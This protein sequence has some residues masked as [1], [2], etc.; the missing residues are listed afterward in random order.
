MKNINIARFANC[1]PT[2]IRAEYDT[3]SL[4]AYLE[5]KYRR[6]G[7]DKFRAEKEAL[8]RT[9]R[10]MREAF[11]MPSLSIFNPKEM[12]DSINQLLEVLPL[13]YIRAAIDR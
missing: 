4:N 13:K 1:S 2:F 6:T 9:S 7:Q 11:L 10:S 3:D 8:T 12:V 5:D